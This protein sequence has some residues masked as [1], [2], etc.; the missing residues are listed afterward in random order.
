MTKADGNNLKITRNAY[1]TEVGMGGCAD[2]TWRCLFNVID[3]LQS[4]V[5]SMLSN[6]PHAYTLETLTFRDDMGPNVRLIIPGTE[7]VQ[8]K[9]VVLGAHLDSRNT[10]SGSN[11]E[12]PAPG[13]DDNGSGSAINMEI[14]QSLGTPLAD[15]SFSRFQYDMHIVWFT[16]EEQGLL[17][18]KALAAE[19]KADTVDVLG[20]FNNDM[21]GYTDPSKG[22]VLSFMSRKSTDWLTEDCK[23]F[24]TLYLPSLAVGGTLG[25]C[26]DQQS[27]DA[28]GFPAAGIFETPTFSV[29]YPQYH[30]SG[31]SWDSGFVYEGPVQG[32][33]YQNTGF[34][35]WCVF[36]FY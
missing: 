32:P 28:A 35:N 11:A 10:N 36:Q 16:G 27:F 34:Q 9:V 29:V 20:M 6:Y 25:C 13:A 18:S 22:M 30:K 12:G 14:I 7:Q 19:Y 1:S 33:E 8:P 4:E 21:V 2:S 23:A 24:S 15:G 31:D 3:D 17:G 5:S 26:S